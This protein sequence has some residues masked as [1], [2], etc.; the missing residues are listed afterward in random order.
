MFLSLG[1]KKWG[2]YQKNG[3]QKVPE[4]KPENVLC[5]V[6]YGIYITMFEIKAFLSVAADSVSQNVQVIG[7]TPLSHCH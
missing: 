1:L 7:P 3:V 4:L 5:A 2:P 6:L